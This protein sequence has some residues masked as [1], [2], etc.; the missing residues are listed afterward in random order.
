MQWPA[1]VAHSYPAFLK[2]TREMNHVQ[3][4]TD[5]GNPKHQLRQKKE[6]I[7]DTTN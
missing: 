2:L 3:L 7:E 6:M 1:I 5:Q 4:M